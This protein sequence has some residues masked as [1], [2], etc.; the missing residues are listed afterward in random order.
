MTDLVTGDTGSTLTATC[1]DSD[2]VVID[3]TGATVEL[4][5]E[6]DD[7]VVVS[8]VMTIDDAAGGIASYTFG[9]GEIFAP[10]M[11]FEVEITDSGGK[12]ITC[13][14]K[15]ELIVREQIG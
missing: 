14:D 2:G 6:G 5:W 11:V 12:I 9:A 7:G 10:K 15:I 4:H 8:E 3:L 1:T 13:V